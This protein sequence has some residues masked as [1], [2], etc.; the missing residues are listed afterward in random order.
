[1]KKSGELETWGN[2]W[3]LAQA[4]ISTLPCKYDF[5]SSG[6]G[7]QRTGDTLCVV[8]DPAAWKYLS[9][10]RDGL[11][12]GSLS[13]ESS[14]LPRWPLSLQLDW[15]QYQQRQCLSAVAFH[16]IQN[17][18]P[19]WE[20]CETFGEHLTKQRNHCA[21]SANTAFPWS[22]KLFTLPNNSLS[23]I[24]CFRLCRRAIL[25]R[26]S[27]GIHLILRMDVLRNVL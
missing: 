13:R 11:A 22:P 19:C 5:K 4:V 9:K 25:L 27:S 21:A 23:P 24:G 14:L 1:M 2:M 3:R 12:I 10:S 20:L 26:A 6:G 18:S 16:C 15:Y 7:V 8:L 17:Q